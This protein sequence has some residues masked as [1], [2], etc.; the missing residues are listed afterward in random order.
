MEQVD[1]DY[2]E[3][4]ISQITIPNNKSYM[5]LFNRMHDL[6]FVWTVPNDD[7]RVQDGL[8]LRSEFMN[9]RSRREKLALNGATILEVLIALSRRV[10]FTAGG[11]APFWAWRLL[12]NLRLHKMDDPLVGMRAGRVEDI[13]EALVWRTYERNGRGGFFPLRR[14]TED[15]TKVEIWYQMQA[16][17]IEM[18]DR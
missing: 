14:A 3:W 1:Y 15:Q 9:G 17:V 7:N 2:F 8:D 5:E 16:Y 12:K 18:Q 10:E 13:L 11:E 4:L 6:E